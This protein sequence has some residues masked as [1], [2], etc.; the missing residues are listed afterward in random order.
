MRLPWPSRDALAVICAALLLLSVSAEVLAQPLSFVPLGSIR[1]PADRIRAQGRLAYVATDRTL[2]IY[3]LVDPGSPARVGG[4]TF[5]EQIWGFRLDGTRAYVAAGHSGL[6]ILD[7]SNP[8]APV[9]MALV[10]MPGQAKNVAVS[11]NRALVANHMSGVD[12]V[13]ISSAMKPAL[14]GSAFVDG[15]ARDVA[16]LGAVGVAVDNPSGMYVFDLTAANTIEPLTTLQTAAAPQQ[17]EMAE[18]GGEQKTRLAVLAGSEPYDPLRGAR[19]PGG[20][21][22]PGS[23]QVFDVSDPMRPVL[24]MTLPTSGSGR[25]LAVRGPLVYLADGPD[26]LRVLDLTRPS[27]PTVVG[28]YKTAAPARD[29]AVADG[30]VLLF[31]DGAGEGARAQEGGEI[32]ILSERR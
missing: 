31:V 26:G 9:L 17:V 4:Y 7:V 19:P 13:D 5:P 6:G 23:L 20:P 3:D 8:A 27:K 25:R 16:A 22:R 1:G 18:I 29:V 15:Y 14:L 28:A 12:T 32:L 11:G 21:T 24:A 2:V 30:V 10:K